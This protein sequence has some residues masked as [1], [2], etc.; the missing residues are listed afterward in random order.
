MNRMKQFDLQEYL[1]NPNLKVVTRDGRPARIICTDRNDKTGRPIVALVY[2]KNGEYEYCNM[3][4]PNGRAISLVTDDSDL[5]FALTKYGRWV[6]VYRRKDGTFYFGSPYN[7]K[8]EAESSAGNNNY[9]TTTK[10][11]W[12]G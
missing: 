9:I 7:T 2:D 8:Q 4:F 6:N 10:V 11:E 3:Y 12:E 5:F 1:K